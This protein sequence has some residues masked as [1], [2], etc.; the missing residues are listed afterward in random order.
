MTSWNDTDALISKIKGRGLLREKSL[1]DGRSGRREARRTCE[2]PRD[3]TP[4]Q[5]D[6]IC[7]QPR[8]QGT[9]NTAPPTVIDCTE[10][11][12]RADASITVER[13]ETHQQPT[14]K[15]PRYNGDGPANT[16]LLQVQLA[17]QLNARTTKETTRH[18]AL[19]LEGSALQILTELQPDDLQDWVVL[20][21][22]IQHRFGCHL[23]ADDQLANGQRGIVESLGAY[24]ADLRT[25]A[26]RGH[27]NFSEEMQEELAVQAF[28]QRLRGSAEG[29]PPTETDV[30]SDLQT[31]RIGRLGHASG[32][33]LDCTLEGIPCR[34]LVDTGANLSVVRPGTLPNFDQQSLQ[35]WDKTDECVTTV[36]GEQA[37]ITPGVRDQP[38]D[39]APVL[40]G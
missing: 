8:D 9:G 38:P 26:C 29:V 17:A 11:A 4:A 13:Q 1:P 20:K 18:V 15:L 28:I 21:T 34:A 6:Y 33:Y 36:T 31:L 30:T 23:S 27:P 24:A 3:N 16:Y 14:H 22:A 19:S 7:Q 40:T 25:Y 12:R 10:A 5:E 32:L 39:A 37:K 35:G 2:S